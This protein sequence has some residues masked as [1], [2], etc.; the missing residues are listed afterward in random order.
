MFN[1]TQFRDLI[2][3]RQRGIWPACLRGVLLLIEWPYRWVMECRNRRYDQG[4]SKI[5]AMEVPVISVGNLTLGGTGKTPLVEWLTQFLTDQD[6][7]VAIVSRG[8]GADLGQKNDEAQ[9]LELALPTV[10]H[11]QNRD[12]VAGSRQAIGEEKAQVIVLDDGFQHRRLGRDLDITLLDATEP[13][14][15]NHVFPRGTLRE[16]PAGL[17]RCQVVMLSRASMLEPAARHAIQQQAASLAPTA[18]WCEVDHGPE[19]LINSEGQEMPLAALSGKR[20]AAFCGIGNPEGFRY[21]LDSF[22]EELV[23]WREFPDH[24]AY[25]QQDTV[26]LSNWAQGA[27]LVICTR[28]DLVKLRRSDLGGIPLWALS[29]RLAFLDGEELFKTVLRQVT[30]TQIPKSECQ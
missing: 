19:K 9:E 28:K 15:F 21:T 16:P 23:R 27:N 22:S 13:W 5:H 8:Y 6:L 4:R 2:S 7:R 26:S 18:L 1:S 10:P 29:I 12:R 20:I 3:G 11:I 30:Q 24:H 17:A 25:T 14:G